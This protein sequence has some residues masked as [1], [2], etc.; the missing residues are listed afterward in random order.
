MLPGVGLKS[1]RWCSRLP[2]AGSCPPAWP[3]PFQG[4]TR[5]AGGRFLEIYLALTCLCP[6]QRSS[7]NPVRL[8]PPHPPPPGGPCLATLLPVVGGSREGAGLGW[9]LPHWEDLGAWNSGRSSDSTFPAWPSP[10]TPGLLTPPLPGP[11]TPSQ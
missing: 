10:L 7:A 3:C 1:C 2:E 8:D 6:P 11:P 4:Q 9:D 5:W